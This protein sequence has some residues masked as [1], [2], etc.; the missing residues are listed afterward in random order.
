MFRRI[1]IEEGWFTLFLVWAMIFTAGLAVVQ[2][3]LIN[4]LEIIPLLGTVALLAGLALAKSRFSD[5]TAHLFSFIYA[6]FVL[7]YLIGLVLPGE[8]PWRDRVFDILNRQI[9][10]LRKAFGEGSSRDGIIFVM[11]TSAVFWLL[12]YTAA[13][14]TFRHDRVWRVVLPTGIVLLS[15]VYF[16]LGPKPLA[17]Y[18]GLYLLLSLL[19][20]SQTH[21]VAHLKE[22]RLAA[23]RYERSINLTFLRAS[24]IVGMLT[25]LAAWYLPALSAS[26]T[27]SD[28]ISDINQPWRSFQD[29]WTRLFSSLRSY[30][31]PISD[32]YTDSLI[33]GGPRTVG[34]NLV[35]DIYVDEKL[36][37]VYWQAAVFDVYGPE[38]WDPAGG[39]QVLHYPEDGYLGVSPTLAREVITQTVINYRASSGVLYGAP[40]IV[41]SDRQMLVTR[42]FDETGH[43]I[44]NSVKSRYVL[45]QGDAYQI[46]SQY[47][48]AD[49]ASLRQATVNYP[50]SITDN[51]LSYPDSITPETRALA[52]RLTAPYDNPFDKAVAVRDYLRANIVYNDQIPAPPDDVDPIH[53]TLFESREGYCNYYATA[54][55]VMLR[56]QGIPAR[57]AAGYAQGEWDDATSSYRVRASNAH[58]WVEVFFPG[59][60]WIQF[61]PTASLPVGDRPESAAG[62]DN[63]ASPSL[64]PNLDRQEFLPDDEFTEQDNSDF[65]PPDLSDQSSALLSRDWLLRAAIGAAV[66]MV[67]GGLVLLGGQLNQSVESDVHK[68]YL[69]LSSWG[70]FLDVQIRPAHTPYERANLLTTQVPEGRAPIRNLTQQFVAKT[71]SPNRQGDPNFDPRQEWKILRPLLLRKSISKWLAR[72]RRR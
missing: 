72:F 13:W 28:A 10:W 50:A 67:A 17:L 61:E 60:G 65:T 55:A 46:W 5:R 12:G 48:A 38:G 4:G 63:F 43:E 59:Y 51:Y 34:N 62:G 15:V 8:L 44:I 23:V 21:L 52:E 70:R 29:D 31:S 2:T 47:S 3:E 1:K 18:L 54:M 49:A 24:L 26:P 39:E 6:L 7:T 53:Y 11:H 32:P 56:L 69:R 42:Q 19:Y 33:L 9:T 22:W 64:P 30:G 25:L 68:S 45:R 16:Y 27:V 71:F 66:L 40:D 14:F 57:V 35:M 36:P 20:V 37:Y 41:A 58:T